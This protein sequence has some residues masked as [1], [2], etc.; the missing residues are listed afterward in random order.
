VACE[1]DALA[2]K[3]W[4]DGHGRDTHPRHLHSPEDHGITADQLAEAFELYHKAFLR[5]AWWRRCELALKSPP[6]GYS[7]GGFRLRVT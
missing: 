3:T 6:G 2:V 7:K 4:M 5:A 1:E